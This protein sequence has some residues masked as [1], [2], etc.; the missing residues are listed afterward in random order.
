VLKTHICAECHACGCSL[1]KLLGLRNTADMFKYSSSYL[2]GAQQFILQVLV[3]AKAE[4]NQINFNNIPKMSYTDA[5][6]HILFPTQCWDRLSVTQYQF[7][8]KRNFRI[9]YHVLHK[10]LDPQNS[11]KNREVTEVM[12]VALGFHFWFHV[13]Y[14][15]QPC[16]ART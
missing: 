12:T 9:F 16:H 1:K 8:E 14:S 2:Q 13:G 4:G 5:Q 3:E 6:P 15:P 10:S 7:L 11:A